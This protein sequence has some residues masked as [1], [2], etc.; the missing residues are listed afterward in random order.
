MTTLALILAAVGAAF[1]LLATVGLLRF[2]DVY[3][4]S[5][6]AGKAATLGIC[7]VL[8]G[9]AIGLG[10][11]GALARAGLAM[12]FLFVGIP[13]AAQLVARAAFRSG[14]LPAAET[15]LDPTLCDLD[16]EDDEENVDMENV[17]Y[18]PAPPGPGSPDRA[19][20]DR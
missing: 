7:G 5:H 10:S 3:T 18:D 19:R 16:D 17:E 15:R 6:A 2:P 20:S 12:V 11:S 1:F 4:R 13:V 9:V 14:V 8:L